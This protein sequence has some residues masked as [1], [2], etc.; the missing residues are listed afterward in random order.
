M[1]SITFIHSVRDWILFGSLRTNE[2]EGK[3]NRKL[4]FN[5]AGIVIDE[6]ATLNV[7]KIEDILSL[8]RL[9]ESKCCYSLFDNKY[10]Q[11]LRMIQFQVLKQGFSTFC[12]LNF[13]GLSVF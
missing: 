10:S 9:F 11:R 12:V 7:F 3:I 4:T 1:F 13:H 5:W 2:E 6:M 8:K